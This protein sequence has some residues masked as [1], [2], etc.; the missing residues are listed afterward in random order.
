[1]SDKPCRSPDCSP[2]RGLDVSREN[3]GGRRSWL[4]FRVRLSGALAVFAPVA[5]FF[6]DVFEAFFF[7]TAFFGEAFFGDFVA[8]ARFFFSGFLPAL[9]FDFFLCFFLLAIRAV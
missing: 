3:A 8:I 9:F 1:M 2:E 7:A 5:F 4:L 6:F